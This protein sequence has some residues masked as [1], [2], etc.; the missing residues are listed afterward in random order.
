MTLTFLTNT[1]GRSCR[2]ASLARRGVSLLEILV[3]VCILAV[4]GALALSGVQRVRAAAAR[5]AC[6]SKLRE[7]ALACHGYHS[8]HYTLPPGCSPPVPST[9]YPFMSWCARLLPH[10]GES[11]L[12][13]EIEATYRAEPNFLKVPHRT[14]LRLQPLL[15]LCPS[16]G[17]IDTSR[18]GLTS[19]LGNAGYNRATKDGV[20]FMNSSVRLPDITDGTSSTIFA[21]ERPASA[22]RAFG[23]WYA[24]W[25]QSRDGS[26]DSTIGTRETN[27]NSPWGQSC[28][29]GPYEFGPGSIHEQCDAFHYWS[30]HPFGGANFAMCDGSVR[31]VQYRGNILLP[32]L[33]TRSAG[34]TANLED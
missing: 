17:R 2:A 12:W 9:G 11:A 29:P 10:L 23:W 24:G 31:F 13:A 14:Y 33:A 19:Y 27:A 26:L 3:A 5:T 8:A 6:Q 15:Y 16:D 4:L 25:G 22:D 1:W 20:L 7:L 18:A 32:A 30:Q 28:P 34:E 21:G